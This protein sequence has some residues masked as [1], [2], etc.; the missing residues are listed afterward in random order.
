MTDQGARGETADEAGDEPA[1]A[2]RLCAAEA[3]ERERRNGELEPHRIC[4]A[5]RQREAHGRYG[6]RRARQADHEADADFFSKDHQRHGNRRFPHR[7]LGRQ[8]E[9]EQDNGDANPVV[10]AALDVQ[11]ASDGARHGRVGHDRFAE[12]RIRGSEDG[13]QDRELEGIE[14]IEDHGAHDEPEDD[15]QWQSD[16]EETGRDGEAAP[17]YGHLD[18]RRIGEQHQRQREFGKE[19][20]ALALNRELQQTKPRRAEQEPERSECDRAAEQAA[21]H[22]A[23]QDAVDQNESS[24]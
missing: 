3:E 14:M 15:R 7:G 11:R 2:A 6:E 23:C 21:L 12:R 4:R 13:G 24:K 17:Q 9:K 8:H 1:A 22:A 5:S 18:S 19:T 20:K 10:E 16:Q